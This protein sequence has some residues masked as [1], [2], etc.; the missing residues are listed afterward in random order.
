MTL[1]FSTEQHKHNSTDT[2]NVFLPQCKCEGK[3]TE[4]EHVFTC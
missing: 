1:D 2:N 4:S 3:R